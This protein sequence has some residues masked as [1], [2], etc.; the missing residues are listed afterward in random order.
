[1]GAGG[2]CV[3]TPGM[4]EMLPLSVDSWGVGQSLTPQPPA[5]AD[6]AQ[7]PSGWMS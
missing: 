2:Q 7:G 3:M 5:P 6:R 1:M 4:L